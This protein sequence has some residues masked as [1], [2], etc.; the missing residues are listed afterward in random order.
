MGINASMVKSLW[1]TLKEV[2]FAAIREEANTPPLLLMVGGTE[3]TRRD[4]LAALFQGPRSETAMPG[5]TVLAYPSPCDRFCI[6]AA[7]R[8]DAIL[9]IAGGTGNDAFDL[10]QKGYT[11]IEVLLRPEIPPRPASAVWDGESP[12]EFFRQVSQLLLKSIPARQT[13]LA[14][15]F[16]ALRPH[17]LKKL[18]EDVSWQNATYI[19]MSGIGELVPVLNISVD[20]ADIIILTKNQAIMAYRIAL[21]MGEEGSAE[22]VLPELL[23]VVGS[24]FLWRQVARQLIGL[25]PGWGV[26]PQVLVAYAGTYTTGMAVYHWYATGRKLS[27][28]EMRGLYSQAMARGKLLLPKIKESVRKGDDKA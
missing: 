27:K 2:N 19:L 28:K 3:E 26:V 20:M 15:A 1:N 4:I 22:D 7:S 21:G 6:E 10:R 12:D 13:A 16:P 24:G 17:L 5:R 8:A 25:I 23:S 11:V 18:V 9:C 14:R